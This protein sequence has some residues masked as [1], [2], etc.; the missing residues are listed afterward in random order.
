MKIFAV[1]ERDI[2]TLA[3]TSRV[4]TAVVPTPYHTGAYNEVTEPYEVYG[5]YPLTTVRRELTTA[6][7]YL[8]EDVP[9]SRPASQH[10]EVLLVVVE[11]REAGHRVDELHVR[12]VALALEVVEEGSVFVPEVLS[13]PIIV[14]SFPGCVVVVVVFR[15]KTA[16][17]DALDS[18]LIYVRLS[19]R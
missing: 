13:H 10:V 19:Y 18:L 3:P 6:V 1:S 12:E 9:E 4:S 15:F 5:C 11:A 8:E 14:P 17:A 7:L 16:F 2:Q